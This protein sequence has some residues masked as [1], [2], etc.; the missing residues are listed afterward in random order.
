L[1]RQLGPSLW[2]FDRPL[3]LFGL[4]IGSRMS[5]IRLSDGSLFVHSPLEPDAELREALAPLGP[6]RHVVAPSK[7]HHF[8]VEA[9]HDAYPEAH[10]YAA[11]GLREKK[12]RLRFDAVLDD[13]VGA[14]WSAEIGHRL[15]RGAPF[16]NEVA[17]H[18]AASRTLLLS[19]LAYNITESAS[20]PTR[21]W[22]WINGSYGRFGPSR[23]VRLAIRDRA[24]ARESL[25]QILRWDFE[26]VIV[27][28]GIVLQHSGRRVL[29]ESFAWL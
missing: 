26:R 10:Y 13:D 1:L 2:V 21:A 22:L 23:L 3:R 15:F 19:D 20:W 9:F 11:P 14:P 7:H 18:H 25:E 4:E 6:V 28:H 29:R 8:F 16:I 24:A 27:A 5:V 12:R 17:F